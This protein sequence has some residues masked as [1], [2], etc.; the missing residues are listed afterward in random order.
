MYLAHLKE[1]FSFRM[2]PSSCIHICM[3]MNM[4]I[5]VCMVYIYHTHIRIYIFIYIYI[6]IYGIHIR[7]YKYMYVCMV[8]IHVHIC[9]WMYIYAYDCMKVWFIAYNQPTLLTIAYTVNAYYF[10]IYLALLFRNSP[11]IFM[12]TH[13]DILVHTHTHTNM[14]THAC[15]QCLIC[16]PPSLE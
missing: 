6:Y 11:G 16:P 13:I 14:N 2:R 3:H 5:C 9:I 12:W 8:H 1:T 4:Y 7:T 10:L 15:I